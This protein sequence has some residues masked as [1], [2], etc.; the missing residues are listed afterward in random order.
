MAD[1]V[2]RASVAARLDLRYE[3]PTSRVAALYE[4]ARQAQWHPDTDIDWSVEV[5]FG[6][7]LPDDSA[8]SMASFAASP[9]A[10][11]GRALWDSFRWELQCWLVSQ[12]L[13]GEQGALVVAGRLVEAVPDLAGKSFAASQ[14]V[15]EA[16][17]VEVF[18]RYVREKLPTSYPMSAPLAAL[19]TDILADERWDVTVLG[20]QILVEGLALAAFR[21]AGATLH[22]DLIKDIA[23]L[24][25]RD[26]ARHVSFGVLALRERYREMTRAEIADREEMVLAAAELTRRRLL[27]EDVWERLDVPRADGLA[28]AL[29]DPMM[30]AFRRTLF[31]KAVTAVDNVGL[32]TGRVRDGLVRLELMAHRP[33]TAGR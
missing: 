6:A 19:I 23:R 13:H 5:P 18:S 10:P 31:A 1:L 22:D 30:T 17:H 11:R 16:R 7:A 28:F 26:E 12:F 21:V 32:L 24:V 3:P 4:R 15:D 14:A 29:A 27:L 33:A 9:L 8:F 2:V 20:M 25:A